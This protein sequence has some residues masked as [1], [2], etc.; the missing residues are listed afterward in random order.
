MPP[1]RKDKKKPPT[2]NHFP[3]TRAKALKQAWVEKAKIKSK[4]K[5]EK[6]KM[7]LAQA[8]ENP[9]Q[10][11]DATN[12]I[13]QIEQQH[14]TEREVQVDTSK[15][16]RTSSRPRKGKDSTAQETQNIRRDHVESSQSGGLRE[17]ARKAYS[18]ESLHTYKSDPLKR[19]SNGEHVKKGGGRGQPN[20]KLRMNAML[21]KIQRDYS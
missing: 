7:G 10:E 17:L 16:L 21:E 15:E 4:W 20:M 3:P 8:P 11:G 13:N 14:V 6:R 19:R 1:T 12:E 2:F 9:V 18:R 5:A